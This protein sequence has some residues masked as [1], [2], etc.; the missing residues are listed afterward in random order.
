[1]TAGIMGAGSTTSLLLAGAYFE[2]HLLWI[3]AMT[4]PIVVV[5]QDSAFRIGT[6]A[7][8]R[9]MMELIARELHPSLMWIILIFACASAFMANIG[10][11]SAMYLSVTTVATELGTPQQ[12]FSSNEPSWAPFLIYAGL[13][14]LPI[15]TTIRGGFRRSEKWMT[16]LLFAIAICFTTVAVEAFVHL[17]QLA[18]FF[19]GFLPS[20]PE[21][22]HG[23]SAIV[24]MAS[25]AGGAVALTAILSYPYFTI[26]AGYKMK[27]M[28][29]AFKKH[30]WSFGIIFGIYSVVILVA[31][32]YRLFPT[33]EAY[34]TIKDA[35]SAGAVLSGVLGP[36][37][38]TAFCI[39]LFLCGYTTLVVVAQL[40]SYFILDGLGM[41][42]TFEKKNKPAM[43]IFCLLIIIPAIAGL[44]WTI[45]EF[46]RIIAAMVFNSITAP[47]AVLIVFLL[48]N[49]RDLMGEY[50][51]SGWR[52]IF[53][54]YST[55]VTCWVAV[56]VFITKLPELQRE[57]Q[58][59]FS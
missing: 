52:N 15:L 49:R 46:V 38:V 36:V 12:W 25:I 21:D 53:L 32:A 42:W 37:G 14:I 51:A 24:S 50:R 41:D 18:K 33:P 10:Q 5:C 30:F 55:L 9:G 19:Q 6:V 40:I 28:P 58:K 22:N 13:V 8:G 59:L 45:P 2:Y 34:Q 57:L 7:G 31:S 56:Q 4:L 44:F 39:G 16:Y 23:R 1:M 35:Q 43:T 11:L 17:D 29:M 20:I 54:A 27:D 26:Q 48:M 3:A 47:L